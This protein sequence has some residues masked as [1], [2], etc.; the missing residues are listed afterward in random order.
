MLA[1]TTGT[2]LIAEPFSQDPSFK[3]SVV[4]ICRHSKEDGTVGFTLNKE[5]ETTLADLFPE[6]SEFNQ[7]LYLGGPVQND[8]L[9]YIHQYPEYFSDAVEVL[10]GVF[11]GGDFEK[12]KT[13]LLQGKLE[14][15][16]LKFFLGYSGW[17]AGQLDE[18]LEDKSWIVTQPNARLIFE[19]KPD[20]IWNE[21]LISMGGKYKMMVHF[22]TD[23]QLN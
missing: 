1:A 8:T 11:W 20:L 13:L 22:P 4:L 2:L 18:E 16:K 23:P 7:S 15:H 21:S 9:H 5:L 14:S 12:F 10:P 3:R 17:D 19:T 6:L